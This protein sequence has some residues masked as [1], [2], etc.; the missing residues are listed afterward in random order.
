MRRGFGVLDCARANL[1]QTRQSFPELRAERTL[2]AGQLAFGAPV[3][4]TNYIHATGDDVHTNWLKRLT[5]KGKT[6]AV[7]AVSDRH[8]DVRNATTAG[9]GLQVNSARQDDIHE[10]CFRE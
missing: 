2:S 10:L 4:I 8:H 6:F 5:S 9:G 1:L 7:L 3:S